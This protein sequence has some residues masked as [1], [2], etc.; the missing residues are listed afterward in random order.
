MFAPRRAKPRNRPHS[1]L[2]IKKSARDHHHHHRPI[3]LRGI[4]LLCYLIIR[5]RLPVYS[6]FDYEKKKKKRKREEKNT[7]F[8]GALFRGVIS[9]FPSPLPP[10]LIHPA[11]F[12]HKIKRFNNMIQ[13]AAAVGTLR[14]AGS[15]Y[16]R[17]IARHRS[18]DRR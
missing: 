6:H 3:S 9:P 14:S 11:T 15:R 18:F 7:F 2:R 12:V 16:I 17:I 4:P 8:L 1:V 13:E 10:S 5:S